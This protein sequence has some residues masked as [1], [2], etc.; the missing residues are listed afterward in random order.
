[1]PESDAACPLTSRPQPAV[2]TEQ[3]KGTTIRRAHPMR[4]R[5]T[6]SGQSPLA[7]FLISASLLRNGRRRLAKRHGR[8]CEPHADRRDPTRENWRSSARRGGPREPCGSQRRRTVWRYISRDPQSRAHAQAL[9]IAARDELGLLTRDEVLGNALSAKALDKTT[10]PIDLIT[11]LHTVEGKLSPALIHR[12]EGASAQTLFHRDLA[13]SDLPVRERRSPIEI[14]ENWSRTQFPK[15][16]RKLGLD[17]KANAIQPDAPLPADVDDRLS[18]L[19]YIGVFAAIRDLHDAMRTSGES[20]RR[21]GALVRAYA[22]MGLLT[23]HHWH[24]AHKVFKAR[25]TVVCAVAR[26]PAAQRFPQPLAPRLR[27]CPDRNAQTCA[28]RHRTCSCPCQG[29][30]QA[31]SRVG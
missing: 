27:L 28:G 26:D 6:A 24:P 8:R 15:V 29:R 23:E 31:E 18:K 14:A 12:G 13:D 9:L 4:G 5:A 11:V 25:R 22:L 3:A 19:S 1:M 20:P 17:G 21:I 16:L 2:V 7:V 30:E 10:S